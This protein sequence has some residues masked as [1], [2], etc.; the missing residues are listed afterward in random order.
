[1]WGEEVTLSCYPTVG[2]DQPVRAA[3]YPDSL[4]RDPRPSL[5][6]LFPPVRCPL[7]APSVPPFKG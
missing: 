7:S 1:M 5:F 4:L 3:P 6:P 2:G